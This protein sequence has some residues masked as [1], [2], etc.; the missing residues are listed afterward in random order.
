M[1]IKLPQET[2][3]NIVDKMTN[4]VVGVIEEC[5][6][7]ID[8]MNVCQYQQTDIVISTICYTTKELMSR[9]SV[10]TPEKLSKLEAELRENAQKWV[11]IVINDK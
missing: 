3:D 11:D 7:P 2:L 10:S 1:T 4:M 8:A 9:A 5:M 6:V